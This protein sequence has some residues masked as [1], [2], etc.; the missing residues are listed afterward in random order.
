MPTVYQLGRGAT[1]ANSQNS[2]GGS[3]SAVLKEYE[4]IDIFPTNGFS[5]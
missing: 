4:F 5:N 2:S 1:V 3:D